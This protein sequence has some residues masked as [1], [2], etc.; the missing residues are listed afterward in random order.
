V[1]EKSLKGQDSLEIFDTQEVFESNIKLQRE[2][3]RTSY[4]NYY[5]RPNTTIKSNDEPEAAVCGK[6]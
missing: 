5:K 1:T 2:V 3:P 6:Y 4:R